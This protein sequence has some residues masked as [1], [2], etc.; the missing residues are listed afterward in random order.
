VAPAHKAGAARLPRGNLLLIEDTLG[1]LRQA[2]K[3]V[4]FD[5]EHFFDG[6]KDSPEYAMQTLQSAARAG[7]SRLVLCDTNGGTLPG[8]IAKITADV[9][10]RFP[11]TLGIHC[12]DDCGM[13]AAGTIAAVEA[14]ARHVQGTFIGFGERC[15]NAALSTVIPV[16]QEKLGYACIPPENMPLLTATALFVAQIANLT[17]DPRAPFVGASAFAHKAGMHIDGVSKL[18][19]TF[20]HIEPERVG[21]TRR[22]LMSGQSGRGALLPTIRK[23]LPQADKNSEQA[24]QLT[25]ALKALEYEGYEY[26]AAEASLE[27]VVRRHLGRSRR[28]FELA[29]YRVI[30][31][32]ESVSSAMVKL[33]VGGAEEIA[34]AEG[35]GPVNALDRALRRALE[36]FYP[37]LANMRLVDYKVRVLESMAAT[38][39]GVRVVIRSSDGHDVWSTVGVSPNIIDASWKALTDSIEYY[40]LK[41]QTEASVWA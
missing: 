1:F 32:H 27:L 24:A 8:E 16:L 38:A 37:A 34:A 29:R 26:E 39:S 7:A 41:H 9:A 11:Q 30:D 28:F 25:Q 6:Y 20:E 13:A 31:E 5:A 17:P 33:R 2:G 14:G 35:N 40:L 4:F 21:N 22:F 36:V 15:G 23:F 10:S 18:P 19:G 12:H 3:E